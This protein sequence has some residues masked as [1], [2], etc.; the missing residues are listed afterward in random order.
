ML[1]VL[2]AVP[3]SGAVKELI[4][5]VADGCSLHLMTMCLTTLRR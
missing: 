4:V 2:I 3:G 5:V 1:F